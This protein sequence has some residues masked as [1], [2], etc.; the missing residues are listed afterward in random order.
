MIISLH[1]PK[2][3]GTSFG[4]ALQSH[5]GDG[6]RRDYDDLPLN[7]PAAERKAAA[8]RAC[9]DATQAPWPDA[10]CVH[11]HFLPVKYLLGAQQAGAHFVSWMRHPVDRLLSHY[12]FWR[13][14]APPSPRHAVHCRMH[15]EDWSLERFC[16]APELRDVY[17]Q[18]LWAFPLEYFEF[19]G[20]TEHYEDDF[21][22]FSRT[23]LDGE[24]VPP[25]LNVGERGRDGG[26]EI[27]PALRARVERFHAR[28]IALYRRA[29][30]MRETRLANVQRE[31]PADGMPGT[32]APSLA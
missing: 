20:I 27:D 30:Q 18:F 23:Y 10:A 2:T 15:D 32:A 11:G 21:A 12:F 3:A 24:A 7:T 25:R 17:A 22:H 19:I 28:D 26:Y 14:H 13:K 8:L 1:L 31:R 9:L 6:L 4:A 5:F 16:L 29:L